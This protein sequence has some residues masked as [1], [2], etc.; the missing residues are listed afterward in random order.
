[1]SSDHAGEETPSCFHPSSWLRD[2]KCTLSLLVHD[3]VA[4]AHQAEATVNSLRDSLVVLDTEFVPDV[5]LHATDEAASC[6]TQPLE[7][8]TL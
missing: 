7:G 5:V 4:Q 8:I 3:M 2:F 1:M 6:S